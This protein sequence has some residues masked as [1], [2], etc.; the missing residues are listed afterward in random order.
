M[1]INIRVCQALGDVDEDGS[2]EMA[3]MTGS[4]IFLVDLGADPPFAEWEVNLSLLSEQ[5]I[6]PEGAICDA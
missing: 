6:L 1:G 4:S 3:L 2:M 5:G